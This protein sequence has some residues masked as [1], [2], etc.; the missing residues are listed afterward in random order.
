M[1]SPSRPA[2]A[3]LPIAEQTP[4]PRPSPDKLTEG[5]ASGQRFAALHSRN[6]RMLWIG[7]LISNAGTWMASTA[8]GWLVTDLQP[9][10]SA[11][12]LGL[13]AAAFA[14]PMLVLPPVGGAVADRVPRLRLL[15]IVQ[16]TYL[17]LSAALA[18][19]TILGHINVWFL[20]AYA[21][22]NGVTLAF[23]SPVRHALLP[24]IVSREQLTSAVSLNSVAFTGAAL[25]GPAIAGALIP[26]IGVSGVFTVNAASCLATIVALAQLR[27]VP[28]HRGR[29]PHTA[30]VFQSIAS[31]ITY[32]VS[33]PLL[34][35][36]LLLS[37][38][39]GLC[40]RS[41]TPLL[42]V[43]AR[44]EF[45]VGST[46]FGFLV[47]AGGLGTL[48]GA[49]W[50]A[51]RRDV[52]HKGRW[53]MVATVSQAALLAAFAVTPWF[54]LALLAL[55]LVG[56][57]GAIAGAM[58]ATLIQ[59]TVPGTLRGRVM[60]LY[61]LTL[62]GVPSAGAL[63]TGV[64]GQAVGVRGAVAGAALAVVIL[65]SVILWRNAEIRGA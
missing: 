30:G 12:W 21:F 10:R 49:F 61:L 43:F 1:S 59:L 48:A 47:S 46:A 3:T 41:Y 38:V 5:D 4:G 31:G 37:F 56:F 13:I 29:E 6:F 18:L 7:L 53:V 60:S 42:A 9:E 58:T 26:V 16:A 65:A 15:W 36:L 25:V 19:L 50:L 51:S 14:V 55:V 8:E 28:Q 20:L 62:V 27:G 17:V 39:S 54:V 11:F 34:R 23:D 57:A 64:V 40:A 52:R 35:G 32:V 45:R 24:D 44:E 22:A 63:L 33:S 2:V